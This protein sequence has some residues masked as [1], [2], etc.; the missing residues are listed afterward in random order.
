MQAAALKPADFFGND[1][2]LYLMED[3]ATGEIRLSIFWEWVRKGATITHVDVETGTKAGD[4]FF[5]YTV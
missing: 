2:I 4:V 1:D 3:M 5:Y